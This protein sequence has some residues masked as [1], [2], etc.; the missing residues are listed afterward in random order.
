MASRILHA[1][2]T[3]GLCAL[4]ATAC[5]PT[6]PATPRLDWKAC[7]EKAEFDC[8]TVQVPV[9]WAK[10]A[11]PKLDLALIRHRATDAEHRIGALLS[12]PGGPGTS[13]VDEI[14]AGHKF[15]PAL[16]ARFDI[17]SLDPRGVKRSNPIRCDAALAAYQPNLVPEQGG[18]LDEI[19][20]YAQALAQSCRDFTGPL[21]EHLDAVSVAKDADAVR[22][23]LGADKVSIYSRSYG[24]MAA[25]E[26]AELFP[27]RIRAMVLDSV[28][29]HSL[30]GRGF[31]ETQASA[32]QDSFEE[33]AGWCAR[34]TACALHDRDVHAVFDGI[35]SRAVAG[36]LRDPQ[37]PEKR[38]DPSDLSTAATKRLFHP[39]WAK[40]ADDLRGLADQPPAEALAP[41]PMPRPSGQPA[42][43][44]GVIACSDWQFDLPDQASWEA[45]WRRQNAVAPTLR[46]HF[47]WAGGSIC[48]GWPIAATNPPHR[49]NVADAPPILVLSSRHDPSTPHEWA[50]QVTAQTS[51]AKMLTYDGWGHS[52]YERSACTTGAADAYFLGLTM[53]TATNCPAA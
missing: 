22:A 30:D 43:W 42:P 45:E 48:S 32:A 15:S 5:S 39:D 49:P 52:V 27:K 41:T 28:D 40:L 24:T 14:L 20:D 44:P 46:A 31:V 35:Y 19:R 9:D 2:V 17:V 53:P 4:F 11:G 50:V 36:T 18:R 13:G 6:A 16:E 10:P 26:Y 51:G 23:A 29:D 3:A 21:M 47:A 34:E 38:L 12:L 33:F 8:T 7:P 1:A 25:Q 37:K